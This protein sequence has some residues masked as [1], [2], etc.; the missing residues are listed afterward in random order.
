MK[1]I[2]WLGLKKPNKEKFIILLV[3]VVLTF[4]GF[5]YFV[6]IALCARVQPPCPTHSPLTK[7]L[8]APTLWAAYPFYFQGEIA[9]S[10][11][12]DH[13]YLD[14]NDPAYT[15]EGTYVVHPKYPFAVQSLIQG[16]FISI[17]LAFELAIAYIL[18]CLIYKFYRKIKSK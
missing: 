18:S 7:V 13:E 4:I 8:L 2:N 9:D 10:L 16:I 11:L 6:S 15:G 14:E 5:L 17:T 1:L 3:I 12:L